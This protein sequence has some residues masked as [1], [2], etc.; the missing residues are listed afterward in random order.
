[1]G[2]PAYDV[3]S[4]LMDARVDISD[5]LEL[6]L[7]SRYAL[8]RKARDP[9][10]DPTRFAARYVVLGA[11]R[12]TKILGIFARLDRRDRKPQYLRHLPRVWSYLMRAFQHP[13]LTELQ[14]WYAAHVPPP[15]DMTAEPLL[16][17]IGESSEP[18]GLTG[19]PAE[20]TDTTE[21]AHASEPDPGASVQPESSQQP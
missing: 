4:L 16:A 18:T 5:T 6:K 12:A 1:M 11:Q 21:G 17:P 7:L 8:G 13:A 14:A 3:A 15:P 19:E 10:F 9:S 2:P 20:P